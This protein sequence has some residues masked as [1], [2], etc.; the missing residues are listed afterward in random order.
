MRIHRQQVEHY[1]ELLA[2][3]EARIASLIVELEKAKSLAVVSEEDTAKGFLL[4]INCANVLVVCN[5]D[6]LIGL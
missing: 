5:L 1:T 2:E 3:K 4:C 6:C